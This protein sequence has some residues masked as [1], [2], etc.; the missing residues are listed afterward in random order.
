M[1]KK[2]CGRMPRINKLE[3]NVKEIHKLTVSM[4][5]MAANM[6]NML[7]AIERQGRL[8]E[9]QTSHPNKYP[10]SQMKIDL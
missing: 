7:D 8:I 10:S 6:E 4:E 2:M 1:Q 9:K 3:E 5:R